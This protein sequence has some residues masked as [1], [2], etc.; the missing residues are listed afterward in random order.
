MARSHALNKLRRC[1]IALAISSAATILA[2]SPGLAQS[3]PARET[4][5]PFAQELQK[6]PGLLPELA[7]LMQKLQQN[8]QFP[9]PRSESRLLPLLPAST[10]YYAAIP[11]YGDSVNQALT[12]FRQE[13]QQSAVL[14][15][16][17]THGDMAAS[18]PKIEEA[19]EKFAQL[20]QYLGDEI[21]F[22]GLVVKEEK[23]PSV[24]MIAEIRK[25]GLDQFLKQWI[26]ELAGKSEL[27]VHVLSPQELA[28][29]N[30]PHHGKDLFIL[31]RPDFVVASFNLATLRS[32]NAALKKTNQQFA[33]TPFGQRIAKEY[34]G[35]A[36]LLAAGD[37]QK[38]ISQVPIT[39]K[40][41]QQVF[42]RSGFA[43]MKYLV[44]KHT[45]IAGQSISEGELNFTAPRHGAAAWLAKPAPLGSLD[46][47]S[48]NAVLSATLLLTSLPQIFEDVKGFSGPSGAGTFAMIAGGEKGLN[49]S[50]KDDL[51]SL[52]SG[53]FTIEMDNIAPQPVWKAIFKVSDAVHLQ[54]TLSTLLAVGQMQEQQTEDAGVTYYTVRVPSQKTPM[55]LGYA[56]V[57]GYLVIASSPEVLTA[58]V[59]LHNS[60]GS[61]AK[62]PKF[63]AT[64]PPGHSPDASALFYQ[65][66]GAVAAL[67]LRQLSP[68][69][70]GPLAKFLK[71][72]APSVTRIYGEES[73]IRE[74]SNGG[75]LDVGMPLIVAA[76]AIPNLLRS[77]I[78]A[79]EASAVGSVRVVY[80]SQTTYADTYP[81]FGFASNLAE[82]GPDP[83]SSTAESAGH[84]NLISK[85]LAGDTCTED[86]WCI[87]SGYR[88]RVTSAS[89]VQ[90]RKEYVVV[91]TPVGNNTGTRT[92]CSTSDGIIHFRFGPP[93]K[94]SPSVTE[95]R[96]WSPL[97]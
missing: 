88:F 62:S 83:R 96:A 13:L 67:Q 41:D 82:L 10:T 37:L 40:D 32:S 49:L 20:H 56:F 7:Q 23:D 21:V 35:G 3:T 5:K 80:V 9:P 71:E 97:Q 31:V 51:L 25:P 75:T 66:P 81:K 70:A 4:D 92:F 76:I 19:L 58:A 50:L 47:V 60:G 87:K 61:L 14:Q 65:S 1:F 91:A 59:R 44:W 12:I 85:T 42:R 78:A 43:D 89:K 6:Y 79:N 90:P 54:K 57:D 84:A 46:F 52:L 39:V 53:E 38:I 95:C 36:T 55:E 16:W 33:A 17:W 11:N 24:L 30:D 45:T 68:E 77:R 22:S 26:P 74:T 28:G 64:L 29:A 69:L 86:G 63:L 94:T 18:R 72:T 48:P 93:L 27:G 73:A 8:V 34:Q 15:N 2:A